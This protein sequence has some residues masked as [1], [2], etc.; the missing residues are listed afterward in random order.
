MDFDPTFYVVNSKVDKFYVGCPSE[1][2]SFLNFITHSFWRTIHSYGYD[3]LY[4]SPIL[5][6]VL[7]VIKIELFMLCHILISLCVSLDRSRKILL[8]LGK[9]KNSSPSIKLSTF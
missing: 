6:N 4:M 7:N 2:I 9:K 1:T 5:C 3:C 8:D